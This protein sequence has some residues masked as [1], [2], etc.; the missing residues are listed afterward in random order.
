MKK[1]SFAL[2]IIATFLTACASSLDGTY[3]YCGGIT[4]TS[5]TFESGGKVTVSGSSFGFETEAEMEYKVEN[6]KVKIGSPEGAIV[7]NILEDGSIEG[8]L[9]IKFTRKER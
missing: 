2:A 7:M 4:S 9:G 6:G 8:P 5:Y 3:T 1:L